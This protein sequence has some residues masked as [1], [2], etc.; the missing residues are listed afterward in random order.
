MPS[1]TK[2]QAAKL[3]RLENR[4][5]AAV[6]AVYRSVESSAVPFSEC[7]K[8]ATPKVRDAFKAA[9]SALDKFNAQMV[10]EGRGYRNGFGGV[11]F[12]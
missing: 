7:F 6:D 8:A 9:D 2:A 12:Y 5:N 10:A 4:R 1:L 11:R 3:T